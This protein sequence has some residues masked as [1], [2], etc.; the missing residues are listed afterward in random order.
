VT[1]SDASGMDTM[2]TVTLIAPMAPTYELA[3]T[4]TSCDDDDGSLAVTI[5][6]EVPIESYILVD[7]DEFIQQNSTGLFEMLPAATYSISLIYADG[8]EVFELLDIAPSEDIQLSIEDENVGCVTSTTIETGLLAELTY[9]WSLNGEVIAGADQP[10]LT[11]EQSGS[12]VV[13]ASNGTCTKEDSAMINITPP[14]TYTIAATNTNCGASD[15][16]IT[17]ESTNGIAIETVTITETG[18]TYDGGTITDLAAGDYTLEIIDVNGCSSNDFESIESSVGFEYSLGDDMVTCA[19]DVVTISSG[20]DVGS[21]QLQWS[22]DSELLPT[23]TADLLVTEPGTYTLAATDQ[24]GC[25][26]TES[27]YVAY[28]PELIAVAG[29]EGT[30]SI[31]DQLGYSVEGAET[32][33]WQSSD[34]VL[35]CTDCADLQLTVM[36]AGSLTLTATDINGCT[37]AET[38]VISVDTELIFPN[39]M[40]PYG[41]NMNDVL[42]IAALDGLTMTNLVVYNQAGRRVYETADYKNDWG[43]TASGGE[44]LPD[45]AYYYSITYG[46]GDL[47]F[48]K[49]HDLTILKNQ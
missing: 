47:Q 9:T 14:S 39:Y 38:F 40:T 24:T 25:T 45:G 33:A 41:D 30:Y 32:I 31:G 36:Q 46:I 12:Y 18:E 21:Y 23:N 15:G 7:A 44:Q 2:I 27:V 10:N 29:E 8:C 35:S 11:V 3:I 19:Q 26:V 42:E 49:V 22:L 16:T 17:I 37:V 20:L 48:T 5:T 6:N 1:V 34:L 13:V 43:G 28:Y 4:G